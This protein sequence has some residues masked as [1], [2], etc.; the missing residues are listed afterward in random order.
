[1]RV[2]PVLRRIG[3]GVVLDSGI[4]WADEVNGQWEEMHLS[5]PLRRPWQLNRNK[6]NCYVRLISRIESNPFIHDDQVIDRD[7]WEGAEVFGDSQCAPKALC[8]ADSPRWLKTPRPGIGRA[9]LR[10]G[11]GEA[12]PPDTPL[13]PS[14][15]SDKLTTHSTRRSRS[16]LFASSRSRL[17]TH[18][19]PLCSPVRSLSA[20]II[21]IY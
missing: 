13:P 21:D 18:L 1:M 10:T 9:S 8:S 20:D 12:Q 19:H 16:T 11:R 4:A 6:N 17:R 2:L 5:P 14:A 3:A 7:L 15:L